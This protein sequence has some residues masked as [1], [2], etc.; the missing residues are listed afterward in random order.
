MFSR[1]NGDVE[2]LLGRL[3]KMPTVA[4]LDRLR[5]SIDINEKSYDMIEKE[6]FSN[7]AVDCNF[8]IKKVLPQ[9]KAMKKTIENFRGIKSN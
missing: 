5:K 9:L 1:P 2:K 7:V 8:F 4:I 3:T 6:K